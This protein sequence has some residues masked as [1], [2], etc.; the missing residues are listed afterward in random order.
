GVY[1]G[2]LLA[3]VQAAEGQRRR[4]AVQDRRGRAVAGSAP[5]GGLRRDLPDAPH[6][7]YAAQ[8]PH[9]GDARGPAAPA[10]SGDPR[11]PGARLRR[12]GGARAAAPDRTPVRR[13]RATAGPAAPNPA[14]RPP[15]A[16]P[17]AEAGH[18]GSNGRT[19]DRVLLPPPP[20]G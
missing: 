19:V 4:R 16:S 8:L 12:A 13:A 5:G 11:E 2:G 7:G 18:P 1:R 3:Q 17:R 6:A 10:A 20:A 9:G 15:G 14:A